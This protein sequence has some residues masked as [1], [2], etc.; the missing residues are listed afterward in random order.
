[1]D[2]FVF[3]DTSLLRWAG[4]VHTSLCSDF[5]IF[6]LVPKGD[7]LRPVLVIPAEACAART[8][9]SSILLDPAGPTHRVK[10]R[11]DSVS[12]RGN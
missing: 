8:E 7:N 12:W 2:S 6:W 3:V 5:Q 11:D 1:M 9:S 4:G 10:P